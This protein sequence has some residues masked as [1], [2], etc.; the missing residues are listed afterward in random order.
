MFQLRWSK[1]IMAS[2]D[3]QIWLFFSCPAHFDIKRRRPTV[4]SCWRIPS[5]RASQGAC[6]DAPKAPKISRRE[7]YLFVYLNG[8][9]F[10][11]LASLKS[12]SRPNKAALWDTKK[13][14]QVST[15]KRKQRGAPLFFCFL[16]NNHPLYTTRYQGSFDGPI[17]TRQMART[18]RFQKHDWAV[19]FFNNHRPPFQVG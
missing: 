3:S 9:I 6:P 18:N 4:I 14:Y 7:R 12:P 1:P 10:V 2:S 17:K 11:I 13:I 16:K 15:L 5:H 8:K 19:K